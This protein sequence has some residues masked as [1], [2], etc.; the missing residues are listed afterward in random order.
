MPIKGLF[1]L[2]E[3]LGPSKKKTSS[4]A[5][6]QTDSKSE[7]ETKAVVE[8]HYK[9]DSLLR[10]GLD[11]GFDVSLLTLVVFSTIFARVVTRD[12]TYRW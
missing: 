12:T 1:L 10:L 4:R 3:P 11:H 7:Q 9:T 6:K 8:E 5:H 2:Q